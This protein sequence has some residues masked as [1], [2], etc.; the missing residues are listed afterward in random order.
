MK[1]ANAAKAFYNF[2]ISLIIFVIKK[3]RWPPHY[4][5]P[6]VMLASTINIKTGLVYIH[7]FMIYTYLCRYSYRLYKR[8]KKFTANNSHCWTYWMKRF[9]MLEDYQIINKVIMQMSTVAN[10]FLIN[11]FST[12]VLITM[13]VMLSTIGSSTVA[14]H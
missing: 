7:T 4:T 2:I 8:I 11:A 5:S 9:P 6:I 1:A 14:K 12:V 13:I 10:L 3:S